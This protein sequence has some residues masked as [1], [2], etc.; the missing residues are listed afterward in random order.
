VLILLV[1]YT[2]I[3]NKETKLN[4]N[5]YHK[6]PSLS[7]H[8]P[9][10]LAKPPIISIQ[11]HCKH[12]QNP[13]HQFSLLSTFIFSPCICHRLSFL[14]CIFCSSKSSSFTCIK[15]KEKIE[16]QNQ[17]AHISSF[18]PQI[19][20]P[21][22]SRPFTHLHPHNFNTQNHT[23]RA[24]VLAPF[25]PNL[26]PHIHWPS[27]PIHKTITFNLHSKKSSSHVSPSLFIFY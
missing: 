11:C 4:H 24:M 16:T 1:P 8:L 17:H 2:W 25:I 20:I 10:S 6:Q 9:S 23:R 12:P 22:L 18:I 21:N 13:N 7:L 14:I 26:K 19:C 15:A 27:I 5:N 3:K